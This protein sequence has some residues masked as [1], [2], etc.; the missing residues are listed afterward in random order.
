[1]FPSPLSLWLFAF[2]WVLEF[3]IEKIGCW[4]LVGL[5][6]ARPTKK[7]VLIRLTQHE[8]WPDIG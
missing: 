6:L 1:V 3:F 7:V 4:H 5:G 8:K 2:F